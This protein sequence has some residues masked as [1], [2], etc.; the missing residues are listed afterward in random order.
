MPSSSSC[1]SSDV[2]DFWR[3]AGPQR[4]F[5]RDVAF[6][7]E[8]RERFLEAHFAAARGELFDWEGSADGVLALLVLLDQFPRNAFRG[9]GH[10]FATDGLAL[11]V[12]RRAV[13]HGLDREVDTELRAFIYLPYEHA[14]NIDAQQE[15]VELM[16]HLGGETLRFAIIHRDL[17]P[18]TDCP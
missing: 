17:P 8:F 9:T 13:A 5:A 2:L 15:G 4:W 10:M 3:H 18:I 14:E 1:Q 7:R 12:A 11:A 6:D 16:T